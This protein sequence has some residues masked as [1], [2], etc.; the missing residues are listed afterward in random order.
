[1]KSLMTLEDQALI[2][3]LRER[4]FSVCVIPPSSLKGAD[5]IWME[6]L[7]RDYADGLIDRMDSKNR[8]E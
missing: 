5:P 8:P 1:M 4:G 3:S 2:Q 7:L 6:A